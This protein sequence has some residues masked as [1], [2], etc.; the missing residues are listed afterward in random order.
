MEYVSLH[1][2]STHSYGDGFQLP[3]EHVQ[4]CAEYGMKA[5]ALT[6]HGN[7]SSHVQLEKACKKHNIKPLFGVEAYV[8]PPK[9][10]RKFH[11][12][13]I[14]MN[15]D[16]LR[17]LNR[18]VTQSWKDFY[19]WPTVHM[20]RLEEF[21]DGLIVLSGCADSAISCTL[22]GGKSL[23]EKRGGYTT[24]QLRNTINLAEW[25]K[26][27]FGDRF[28]LECQRFEGLDRTRVLNPAF[29]IVASE[30]G[31]PLVATSDCHY[32][33]PADNEMQKILHAAH[34]GSTVSAVEASW[35]YDIL[36][37]IPTSDDEVYKQLVGTGLSED[38]AQ[39]ALLNTGRI[40]DRCDAHLEQVETIKYPI[41][42][43]DHVP[44]I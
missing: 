32:V 39:E 41:G 40:A 12:T 21:S 22:L 1:H 10:S 29:E 3:E 13:I 42:E 6:E 9:E 26:N 25:Y 15:Q 8:A 33:N 17:N 14:A 4:F 30:T 31:I 20:H 28:Y 35:E 27:I 5:M 2:H 44:W 38:G 23:G 36:L 43:R 11:Q 18:L 7:L 34:R 24:K 16:G 19:R 37:S